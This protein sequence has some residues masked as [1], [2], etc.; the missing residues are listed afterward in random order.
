MSDGAGPANESRYRSLRSSSPVLA[1]TI[2]ALLGSVGFVVVFGLFDL[3]GI[4]LVATMAAAP[5]AVLIGGVA[6]PR[7]VALGTSPGRVILS[8]TFSTLVATSTMWDP[9]V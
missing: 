2:V 9:P 1:A 7:V 8:M 3:Q 5:S 4:A 6:T